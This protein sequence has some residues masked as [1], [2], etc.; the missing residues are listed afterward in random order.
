MGHLHE[1]VLIYLQRYVIQHEKKKHFL[2]KIQ[3]YL[4]EK[5]H[6]LP[7]TNIIVDNL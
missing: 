6:G 2:Y 1:H 7:C 5:S 3:G 4:K